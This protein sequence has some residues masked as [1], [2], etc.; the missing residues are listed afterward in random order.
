DPLRPTTVYSNNIY[1]KEFYELV[2]RR[3]KPGGIIM[4]WVNS[5][6]QINTVASVFPY[7]RQ[8]CSIYVLGSDQPIVH[9]RDVETIIRN[10]LPER[11]QKALAERRKLCPPVD[12][13]ITF[14]KTAPIL[15]DKQPVA[16]YHLGRFYHIWR[17]R[18]ADLFG[19]TKIR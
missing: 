18:N 13:D 10:K 12:N 6:E 8:E 19:T 4:T 3:M 9:Y 1:S 7:V 5:A 2:K 17:A 16:E 14:D 11:G 15:S